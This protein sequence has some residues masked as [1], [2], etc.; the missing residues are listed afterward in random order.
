M[1]L[2]LDKDGLE[3][4]LPPWQLELMRWIWNT[5]REIDTRA[6]Y[7]HLQESPTPMSRASAINFLNKMAEEGYLIYRETTTKGGHKR[8]YKPSPTTPDED[9]FRRVLAKRV[10]GRV[11]EEIATNRADKEEKEIEEGQE[12]QNI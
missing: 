7:N 12:D 5:D 1:K 6:A 2:D 3:M 9:A 8:L 11:L 10:V 4:A